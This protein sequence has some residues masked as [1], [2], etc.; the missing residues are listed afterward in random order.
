MPKT[1][2]IHNYKVRFSLAHP[3]TIVLKIYKFQQLGFISFYD[4]ILYKIIPFIR[5]Y[6]NHETISTFFFS[7]F[8]FTT[9]SEVL[10]NRSHEL[11]VRSIKNQ[12]LQLGKIV[13]YH[14]VDDWYN[15]VCQYGYFGMD[16]R[17][18]AKSRGISAR[19]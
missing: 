10:Y 15:N 14:T 9:K 18:V 6:L 8:I 17:R 16:G 1:C 12:H 5:H 13:L 3:T 2:A 19:G 4:N 7:I 11:I